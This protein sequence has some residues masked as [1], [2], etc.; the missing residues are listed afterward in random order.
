MACT[1]NL[2]ESEGS[3][4]FGLDLIEFGDVGF[5][6]LLY[7]V[8]DQVYLFRDGK[9][10]DT[11]SFVDS[12]TQ[13]V[14][15][16]LFF[17]SPQYGITT[18]M[19][20][21]SDMSG[22]ASAET[23]VKIQ[24]YQILE[25]NK[26][27]V[28]VGIAIATLIFI[29]FMVLDTI[30]TLAK[31]LKRFRQTREFPDSFSILLILVDL[32]S[33]T[34]SIAVIA[35]SIP[36]K[37]SS[38]GNVKQILGNLD[39][40]PWGSSDFSV[41]YKKQTF[42]KNVQ[43]MLSLMAKEESTESFLNF[44][45]LLLLIRV[46]QCTSVHPRLALLTGTIA[47]AFDDFIHTI[48]LIMLIMSSF[49]GIGTWRFGSTNPSYATWEISMQTEFMILMG[50]VD[51]KWA[52]TIDYQIFN[53]LYIMIMFLLVLNFVLAI[54]VEAYMGVRQ[55]NE[56]CVIE[57]DFL[58]DLVFTCWSSILGWWYK[59]PDGRVLGHYVS[60]MPAKFNISFIDLH[61]SEM[62]IS[63]KSMQMCV[64]PIVMDFD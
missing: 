37:T 28:F 13:S 40:I 33:I 35:M 58:S 31:L 60:A 9:L 32:L 54:I 57:M 18:V 51:E 16:L 64:K 3:S 19:T 45:L 10:T 7:S 6:D 46:I 26:M 17:F 23:A 11:S 53:V 15:I 52:S 5:A 49:A 2:M 8:T 29:L 39:A 1:G 22:V 62:F 41:Q 27:D 47:K 14:K 56:D 42:F 38:A 21:D 34:T 48:M 50:A 63:M 43:D 30:Q 24:H 61:Q 20:V 59:W 44:T 4:T 55:A 36:S 12:L 25:K